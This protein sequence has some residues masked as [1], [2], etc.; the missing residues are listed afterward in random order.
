M[1]ERAKRCGQCGES[2]SLSAF[3]RSRG[4]KDGRQ[5]NCKDCSKRIARDWRRKHP[6]K[7]REESRRRRS[8]QKAEQ[9]E[10]KRS[11]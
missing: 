4:S 7:W 1:G 2:K 6:E 5:G 10:R 8:A 3:Y 9:A 11:K